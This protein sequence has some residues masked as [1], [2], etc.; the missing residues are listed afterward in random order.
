MSNAFGLVVAAV[1]MAFVLAGLAGKGR[2]SRPFARARAQR[3]RARR[4]PKAL[5]RSADM[6]IAAARRRAGAGEPAI[7]R[8]DDVMDLAREHFGYPHPSRSDAAAA[9]RR[10]YASGGCERDCVTD[11]YDLSRW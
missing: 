1:G 3:A 6:A 11:A 10:R 8:T 9:L 2:A 4:Y 5:L 7:V